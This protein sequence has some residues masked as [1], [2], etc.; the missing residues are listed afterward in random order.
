MTFL[1][2][3][4]EKLKAAA[5]YDRAPRIASPEPQEAAPYVQR[6]NIHKR[7][8]PVGIDKVVVFGVTRHEA[9][10]W[11]EGRLKTR[12]YHHDDKNSKTLIYYDVIPVDAQPRE[13]SIYYNPGP[14]VVD[15]T[16]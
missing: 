14:I 16:L 3:Q 10:R 7:S 1:E 15:G 12:L 4:L 6:F 11:I 5:L 13:R 2:K 9:E 8:L